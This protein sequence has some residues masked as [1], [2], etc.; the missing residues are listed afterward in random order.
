VKIDLVEKPF[1]QNEA[2][3]LSKIHHIIGVSSCKGKSYDISLLLFCYII[4]SSVLLLLSSPGGVGKSTIAVN[5]ACALAMKGL[6]VGILDAD[7]YGPSLPIQLKAVDNKVKRSTKNP[8]KFIL[9]LISKDLPDNLTM[10]SFG[11]VN[12]NAGAPGAVR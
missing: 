11:H 2:S 4:S 8:E 12:P 7:I 5:L 6:R 1:P 10:L 9:P 3:V